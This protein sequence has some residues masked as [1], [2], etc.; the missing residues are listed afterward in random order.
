MI[1]N[2]C[3]RRKDSE[4]DAEPCVIRDVIELSEGEYSRFSQ[5]LLDD[6]DFISEHQDAMFYLDGQDYALLVLGEGQNDGILVS[7]EGSNYARY[8][9]F[10]PNAREI[11]G[12]D[13]RQLADYCIREGTR[14]TDD[15]SWAVACDDL[16]YH[17]DQTIVSGRNGFGKL[18]EKELRKRDEINELIMTEDCIEMTYHMEYCPKCQQGGIEGALSLMSLIGCNLYDV[19]L[20]DSEEDHE[21]A[22]VTELNP[23]TLT[24]EGKKEWAD[25]LGAKV[26]RIFEGT[27][28]V[29]IEVTGCAAE[30]LRDFSFML[31]GYC[32]AEDYDRWVNS[33]DRT[34]AFEQTMS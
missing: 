25:V 34:M 30:R 8:S 5:N 17:F 32:S 11:I 22:T 23:D 12:N 16:A 19:H 6:Y 31:A 14:N 29:Q 4:I 26:T 10:I 21:L 15:G 24:E 3:W 2:V 18:L 1:I 13:I 28:G 20:C 7:S 33:D 27:Y 9:A